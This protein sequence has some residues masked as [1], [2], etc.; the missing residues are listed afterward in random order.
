L[1]AEVLKYGCSDNFSAFPFENFLQIF[2][3]LVRK[4]EKPLQQIARRYE[5]QQRARCIPADPPQSTTFRNEHF[6]GPLP[7]GFVSSQYTS[8]KFREFSLNVSDA[9]NCCGLD[10]GSI[11]VVENFVFS[12]RQKCMVALGRQFSKRSDFYTDPCASSSL[13]IL[14][15]ENLSSLRAFDVKRIVQKYY[16]MPISTGFVV[17]LLHVGTLA[18]C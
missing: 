13:G 3:K 15:V 1:V 12:R 5:E 16:R 4:S 7:A 9:N 8:L 11:I 18:E 2:K 6:C 10:D 17:P 14:K